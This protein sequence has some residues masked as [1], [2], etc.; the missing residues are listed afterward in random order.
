MSSGKSYL[1]VFKNITQFYGIYIIFLQ[2][3]IHGISSDDNLYLLQPITIDELKLTIEKCPNNKSPG[4]D[5]IGSD[6]YKHAWSFIKDDFLE[7]VNTMFIECRN[8]TQQKEGIVVYMPKTNAPA[9]IQDYRS[10]TLINA[11]LKILAFILANRIKLVIHDKLHERQHCGLQNRSI[12][13]AVAKLRNIIT[14]TEMKR[15]T[16]YILSLV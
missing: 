4:I 9:K 8:L 10:L 2:Q 13:D 7:V 11:D 14:M 16:I 5:G 3:V 1:N 15:E 6:F 12:N